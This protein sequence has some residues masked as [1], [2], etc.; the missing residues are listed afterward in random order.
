MVN[1]VFISRTV[2]FLKLGPRPLKSMVFD[3]QTL[4]G[5]SIFKLG[6][7]YVEFDVWRGY[8]DDLGFVRAEHHVKK[9]FQHGRIQ[10]FYA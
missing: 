3:P 1:P 10:V 9:S 4:F 7:V 2:P 6:K 5:S 8:D